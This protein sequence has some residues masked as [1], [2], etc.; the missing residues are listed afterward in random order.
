MDSRRVSLDVKQGADPIAV[1]C[2]VLCAA[3]RRRA[4][5]DAARGDSEAR[6]FVRWLKDDDKKQAG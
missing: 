5:R 6:S 4:E 1:N 3:V 2:K